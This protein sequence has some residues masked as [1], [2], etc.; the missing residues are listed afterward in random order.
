MGKSFH[1]LLEDASCGIQRHQRKQSYCAF[2]KISVQQKAKMMKKIGPLKADPQVKGFQ[3][4][5]NKAE[6][7]LFFTHFENVLE[8]YLEISNFLHQSMK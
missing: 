1:K 6:K 2:Q 4:I 8:K 7:S 3:N 5:L